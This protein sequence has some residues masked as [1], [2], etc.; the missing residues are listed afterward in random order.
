MP[1]HTST[2]PVIMSA[3]LR[4]MACLE[5]LPLV[6]EEG[7]VGRDS[8]ALFCLV[9]SSRS[10]WGEKRSQNNIILTCVESWNN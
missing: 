3:K 1:D 4:T 8:L 2:A 10:T 6:L 9:L 5:R 7:V